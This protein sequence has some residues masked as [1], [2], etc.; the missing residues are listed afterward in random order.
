MLGIERL[1]KTDRG[2]ILLSI[3]A[4]I[5]SFLSVFQL[6]LGDAGYLSTDSAAIFRVMSSALFICLALPAMIKR[7][8]TLL[9]RLYT[10][11]AILFLFSLLLNGENIK[12]IGNEGLKL[13]LAI[14][15]PVF[16]SFKSINNISF[17]LKT[18]R[19]ISIVTLVIGVVYTFYLVGGRLSIEDTYNM[20]FGYAL[21]LPMMFLWYSKNIYFCILSLILAIIV[22]FVGSRGPF[23]VFMSYIL[24]DFL[25]NIRPVFLLFGL[26]FGLILLI[27]F[28]SIITYFVDLFGF[29]SRT[30]YLLMSGELLTHSSGRDGLYEKAFTEIFNSP[31]LGYG[32][33]GART[34]IGGAFPHNMC[35]EIMLDF[36]FFIGL[37]LLISL[38]F[39]IIKIYFNVDKRNK[40][41]FM[42]MVLACLLP[43]MVSG[44]YVMDY[45]F[46]LLMGLIF[47][48]KDNKFK[49]L[50]F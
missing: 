22:F 8:C 18:L 29:E 25:K 9:F 12:Y 42:M 14:C 27:N 31:V 4:V 40:N 3:C 44:S 38:F 41:F 34:A 7:N 6:L 30:I 21:L 28:E 43:L 35:L 19:Y 16:V 23:V 36:G 13:T 48:Y 33:Y 47:K 1:T 32:I 37:V 2:D 45:N 10:V 24:Y 17:F 39:I 20:S 26:C 11:F 15:I 50:I 49:N 5:Q 46:F